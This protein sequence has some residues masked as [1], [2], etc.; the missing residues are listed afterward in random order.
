MKTLAIRHCIVHT[1]AAALAGFLDKLGLPR[2]AING[3]DGA[4]NDGAFAGAIFTA[5]DSWIEAWPDS[6]EMP[7]CTMLQ[8]LV[9]D[10]DAFATKAR[11]EGLEVL[12]PTDVH[13][14]RIYFAQAPAGV[15]LT[16]Q[17]ALPSGE[18]SPA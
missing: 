10:A 11:A 18:A 14:E 5:G 16:V 4:G 1:E 12:G 17:S 7:A 15:R 8:I 2:R 13:G 6:P 9:D 3:C